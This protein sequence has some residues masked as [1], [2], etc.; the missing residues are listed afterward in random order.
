MRCTIYDTPTPGFSEGDFSQ[1]EADEARA[2][3]HTT[4]GQ[5]PSQRARCAML[6]G[7][8]AAQLCWLQGEPL[9]WKNPLSTHLCRG[10]VV[11]TGLAFPCWMRAFRFEGRGEGH[12]PSSLL[13][14]QISPTF[15]A[16]AHLT[17]VPVP[18]QSQNEAAFSVQFAHQKKPRSN[19]RQ[20]NRMTDQDGT[21][22]LGLPVS[23]HRPVAQTHS[24]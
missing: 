4:A 13:H 19:G 12:G 1:R 23:G 11:L 24:C 10:T 5:P 20:L 21:W 18:L 22:A 17:V 6:S 2:K 14:Y 15:P 3:E 16:L 7:F 8:A 9:P